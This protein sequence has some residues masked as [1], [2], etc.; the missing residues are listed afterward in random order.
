M[1]DEI[2]WLKQTV[3]NLQAQSAKLS[4]PGNQ[5]PSLPAVSPSP[6]YQSTT[7]QRPDASYIRYG[8]FRGPTSTA[9]TFDVANNTI[10]N[11]G[12]RGIVEGDEQPAH[13]V[14]SDI[15]LSSHQ[16]G[17]GAS[18]PLFDYDKDEMVHLCRVHYDEVGVMYPVVDFHAAMDH[19]RELAPFI[20]SMRGQRPPKLLNDDKTLCL[21]IIMC[22]G[23]VLEGHGKSDRATRLYESM[24]NVI[25]R[26]F[27]SDAS[28][29]PNLSLMALV[30]CYRFLSNDE[31]LAWRVMGHVSRLCLELGIHRH[32]ALMRVENDQ[33]KREALISFWTAFVLDRVWAFGTGLPYVIQDDEIDPNLPIP[34]RPHFQGF[35]FSPRTLTENQDD[36]PFLASMV[37]FSRLC[38]KVWKQ[39]THFEP[40]LARELQQE[41][42]ERLD[43]EI[44]QWFESLPE[45]AKIRDWSDQ[46]QQIPP[47]SPLSLQQLRAWTYLRL[48]Q[49]RWMTGGWQKPDVD[50]CLRFAFGYI[51]QSCI[52]QPVSCPILSKHNELS[53]SLEIPSNICISST[54]RPTCTRECRYFTTT[55]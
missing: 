32:S 14:S 35:F 45:E 49:V 36:T 27:M 1:S 24:E 30:A 2:L 10:S 22:A 12:Y 51:L 16:D 55:S 13:S 38:S 53:I 18:D 17:S 28:S 15:N 40:L 8:S 34:V 4:T 47:G 3:K 11:M 29:V 48:H 37:S 21:K 54:A 23:L 50:L 44:L 41:E 9:Y 52:V 46:R 39:V 43:S 6:S 42:L 25:N 7:A 26:K 33:E 31:I 20:E 19:A 5:E